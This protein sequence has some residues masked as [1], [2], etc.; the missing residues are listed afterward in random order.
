M[1]KIWPSNSSRT[2]HLLCAGGDRCLSVSFFSFFLSFFQFL[3]L[4]VSVYVCAHFFL[5]W[6]QKGGCWLSWLSFCWDGI[7]FVATSIFLLMCLAVYALWKLNSFHFH[8][9][10]ESLRLS[11]LLAQQTILRFDYLPHIQW[12]TDTKYSPHFCLIY[13]HQPSNAVTTVMSIFYTIP[14]LGFVSRNLL[15]VF[16]GLPCFFIVFIIFSIQ[17]EM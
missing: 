12:M 4:F 17:W 3:L 13:I 1:K 9:S 16:T 2:E 6:R 8:P 7:V 15:W 11:S 5:F 14:L 10:V